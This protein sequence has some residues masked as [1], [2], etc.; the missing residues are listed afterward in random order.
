MPVLGHVGQ[1]LGEVGNVG[2]HDRVGDEAGVFELLLLLDGIAT[3][4]DVAEEAA[5]RGDAGQCGADG[6]GLKKVADARSTEERCQSAIA[7]TQ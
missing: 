7:T 1:R 3:L 5:G 2:Q 6:R 4:D